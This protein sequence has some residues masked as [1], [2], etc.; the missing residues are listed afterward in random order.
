[1]ESSLEEVACEVQVRIGTTSK[2]KEAFQLAGAADTKVLWQEGD[3]GPAMGGAQRKL[4][5]CPD[6]PRVPHR[7]LPHWAPGV[8]LP[9]SCSLPM[10]TAMAWEKLVIQS[11]W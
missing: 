4:K 9:R 11:Y 5:L 2:K 6:P 1:M 3:R 10:P 7:P 8:W